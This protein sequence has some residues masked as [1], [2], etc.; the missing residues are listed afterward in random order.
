MSSAKHFS[1]VK[2]ERLFL[3]LFFTTNLLH[4]KLVLFDILVVWLMKPKAKK[5]KYDF[6]LQNKDKCK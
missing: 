4:K 1:F 6:P 2:R 5:L 3:N